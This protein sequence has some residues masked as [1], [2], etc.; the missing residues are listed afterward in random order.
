MRVLYW[1]KRDLRLYDNRALTEAYRVAD[2]VVAIYVLD[3]DVIKERGIDLS[4]RWVL[5][6]ARV[7]EEIGANIKLHAFIGKTQDVFEELVDIYRFD[8]VYTASPL[9]WSEE[10]LANQVKEICNRR[11][12]LYREVLD[13][14]LANIFE[15]ELGRSFTSFYRRWISSVDV[16]IVHRVPAKK[17]IDIGEPG[18]EEFMKKIGVKGGNNDLF[19]PSWGRSRLYSFDFRKYDDL[20]DYPYID[21]TSRLSH[22]ISLGAISIRE[23]FNV[24]KNQS[25]EFVRQLAWRDYYYA[26][27]MRYPWMNRLEL[28]PYMRNFAWEN[29]KYY[30]DCFTEGKTGYPIVDAGVR[31]LKK[32]GWVHNRVRLIIASFLV[33]D[34]LTDWRIGEE[35]FRKYLVDYDEV[36]NIGNWQWVASVG[37]DPLPMRI[38]NPIKQ[39]EK[40]DP[41]CLYIKRYI[42]E[43]ESYSCRELHNPIAHK[44][45]GY[46]EPIVDHYEQIKKY[47]KLI[48]WG[49]S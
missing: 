11:G 28:K 26:L 29:N 22:F 33:K 5:F 20:K 3:E 1:F 19:K 23:V 25:R 31:Q 39:S 44:I 30:V 8:A 12:L 14:V 13:N 9:S 17:F 27:R 10:R 46:Y 49:V 47:K 36:L 48:G 6:L 4:H 35:F 45:K 41:M 38:F 18:V 15:L 40:Y 32:E 34:L 2:E 7:L 24:A 21:G 37:V 16:A 43:L 42:P